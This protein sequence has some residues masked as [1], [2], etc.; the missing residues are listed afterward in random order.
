[1][2]IRKQDVTVQISVPI[3][4]AGPGKIPESCINAFEFST[5]QQPSDW[6]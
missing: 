4:I 3:N 2:Y 5:N 1:L 6:K